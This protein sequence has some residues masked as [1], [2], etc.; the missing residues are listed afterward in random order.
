MKTTVSKFL[1]SIIFALFFSM[2]LLGQNIDSLQLT[3]KEIPENYSIKNDN[4]CISTQA[5][6]LFDNPGIYEMIIGK[7]KNK[8]IQ[9]FDSKKESG[10]IIYFEFES[11]FKAKGFLEGLLWGES[12]PSKE[13][14]EEYFSN[15]NFLVIWSFKKG[16]PVKKI[17]ED[18][19][20]LLLK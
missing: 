18:K 14:P 12:K 3:A 9:S 16:S 7:V 13:H 1:A 2:N 4:N 11:E 20:K 15:G 8:R 6:M 5:R 17:S 19:I 10:C